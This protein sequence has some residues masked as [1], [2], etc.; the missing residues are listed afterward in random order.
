MLQIFGE[1]MWGNVF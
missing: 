1:F